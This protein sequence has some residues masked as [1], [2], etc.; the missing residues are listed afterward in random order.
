[1]PQ[2]GAKLKDGQLVN[3]G[4]EMPTQASNYLPE[5]V[6][7]MFHGENGVIGVGPRPSA[8]QT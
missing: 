8:S 3:L 7:L 5:S 6:H 4:F 2:A 1:M